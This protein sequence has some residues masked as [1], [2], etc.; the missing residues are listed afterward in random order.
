MGYYSA[1]KKNEVMPLAATW[2]DLEVIVLNEVSW[3][4]TDRYHMI[5]LIHRLFKKWYKRAY[6]EKGKEPTD[7]E[8][9]LMV[10]KGKGGEGINQELETN[11]YT[12]LCLKQITNKDLLYSIR[13]YTQHFVKTYKGK[14]S[15]IYIY[16]NI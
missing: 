6:V 12:L 9:E 10:T 1:I 2:L 8:N 16:S 7:V 11:T 5:S 4:K 15:E 14:Q 13:N 3:T